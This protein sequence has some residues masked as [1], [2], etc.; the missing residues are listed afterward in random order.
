MED[1]IERLRE[2]INSNSN[3]TEKFKNSVAMVTDSLVATFPNYDF[4]NLEELLPSLKI[5]VDDTID[6]YSKYDRENNKLSFNLD[7]I[8]EDRIDAQHLFVNNILGMQNIANTGYEAFNTGLIESI[9]MTFNTDEIAKKLNVREYTL[10][11]IFSKI[12]DPNVLLDACF[13]SG[14]TNIII[15]LDTLGISKEEFDRLCDCFTNLKSDNMAFTNAECL[16]IDMFEKKLNAKGEKTE[17]EVNTF[18]ELLITNRND[19][20]TMYPYHNFS[21]MNGF[22]NVKTKLEELKKDKGEEKTR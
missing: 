17:E 8:L 20:I 21:N 18:N 12:A 22:E 13:M 9:C 4:K 15:H 7:K 3:L 5:S 10:M 16:M 1:E 2:K 14:I 11:S 6:D 19:L